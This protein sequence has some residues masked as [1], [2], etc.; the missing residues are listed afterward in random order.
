MGMAVPI[1]FYILTRI[2]FI[3]MEIGVGDSCARALVRHGAF[4]FSSNISASL[5]LSVALLFHKSIKNSQPGPGSL[6][7]SIHPHT[8]RERQK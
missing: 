7:S 5:S 3:Q 8:E 4:L 2:G 1:A 6:F